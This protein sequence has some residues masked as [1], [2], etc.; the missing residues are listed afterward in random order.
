[1]RFAR[2]R[3]GQQ[4]DL[5]FG[6]ILLLFGPVILFAL[7]LCLSFFGRVFLSRPSFRQFCVFE[8][9]CFSFST[10]LSLL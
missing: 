4:R 8:G 7:I 1:M 5:V 2:G 6:P 10:F 9:M 3:C